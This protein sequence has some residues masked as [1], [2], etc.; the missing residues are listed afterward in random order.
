MQIFIHII[1]VCI[2]N[3]F[4]ISDVWIFGDV[5]PTPAPHGFLFGVRIPREFYVVRPSQG[6]GQLGDGHH[7]H[8]GNGW[9]VAFPKHSA[10]WR[11]EI[12]GVDIFFTSTQVIELLWVGV[13]LMEMQSGN[14]SSGWLGWWAQVIWETFNESVFWGLCDVLTSSDFSCNVFCQK[15]KWHVQI[16]PMFCTR[17]IHCLGGSSIIL[18]PSPHDPKSTLPATNRFYTWKMLGQVGFRTARTTWGPAGGPSRS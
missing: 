7:G 2:Q 15:K 6:W 9:K 18:K 14:V 17:S 1:Q 3:I 4:T 10:E 5:F 12:G 11:L 13:G 16:G 8:C